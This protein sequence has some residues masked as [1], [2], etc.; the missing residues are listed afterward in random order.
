ML[1][2]A[3]LDIHWSTGA[4][5]E[6]IQVTKQGDVYVGVCLRCGYTVGSRT[7]ALLQRILQRHTCKDHLE[8]PA[9]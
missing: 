9:H 6:Q 5:V 1:Q 3:I 8:E 2:S 4:P 7:E